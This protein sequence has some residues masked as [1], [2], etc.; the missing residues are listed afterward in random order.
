MSLEKTHVL[1]NKNRT[2]DFMHDLNAFCLTETKRT[3]NQDENE[4][5]NF[6]NFSC[7]FLNSNNFLQF[8]F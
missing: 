1:E 3:K 6:Y 2:R 5:I 7:M 8:E 4:I